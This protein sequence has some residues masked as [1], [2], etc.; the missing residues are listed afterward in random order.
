MEDVV[1]IGAGLSGLTAARQLHRSGY[2]VLV[3][4]KSRGLGGRLAT[5]RLNHPLGTT[6]IDHGC[7]Y[8]EPFNN[9]SLSPIAA[10]LA[11]GVLQPWRP[12]T[13]SLAAEG[14]LTSTNPGTLYVAPQGISAVA[15][16]LAPGLTIARHWR[17]TTLT[18]IPQGW[19]V[20][21]ESLSV[22]SQ[23]ASES[24]QPNL[25]EARAVVIAIPAP[26]AAA[27]IDAAAQHHGGLREMQQQLETVEF[28]AV[29]TAIAGYSPHQSTR[30]SA[31]DAPGGWLVTGDSHPTLRWVALDSSKRTDSKEPV[32]VVHSSAAFAASNIDRFD[33]EQ[34]GKDLLESAAENLDPWLKIPE[35]MQV[36]RWRYGFV[37]KPLNSPALSS[38]A[39]PNLVGCG[40]WCEGGNAEGAI[41]SGRQAAKLIAQA[42]E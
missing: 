11:D 9:A 1:V 13:F 26:Q 28:E 15:K 27:L 37:S 24:A 18:P 21:G 4:D 30:L 3:V 23:D 5:R 10:L 31:Q 40:D 41:A 2:R 17:A 25:I 8:L 39:L 20:A 22:G 19:R 32:V 42:L 34:V 6:A 7:R 16:A 14:S 29:I 36:H 38:S 12:E 33:L 35:W